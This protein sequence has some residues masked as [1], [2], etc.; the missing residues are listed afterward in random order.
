MGKNNLL[1]ENNM[2]GETK[3]IKD[4]TKKVKNPTQC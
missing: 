4:I 2:A 3:V 1:R